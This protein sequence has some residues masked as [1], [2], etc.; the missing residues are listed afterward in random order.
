[1]RKLKFTL[2]ELLVVIAIIAILAAML[3]PALQ[4]ARDRARA[5]TCISNLKQCGTLGAQYMD[6]HNGF[7]PSGNS[8]QFMLNACWI[9][10]G[11]HRGKYIKLDDPSDSTWWTSFNANRVTAFNN[12][13]P[14][15]LRCPAVP[16]IPDYKG[17]QR[18]FIQSYGSNY[19]NGNKPYW[20]YHAFH[21]ALNKGY[22]GNGYAES[23]FVREIGPSDRLWLADSVN[24]NNIQVSIVIPW[25]NGDGVGSDGGATNIWS[26]L[27]PVHSG[28]LN[29]LNFSGGVTSP[30]P[31]ELNKY[32]YVRHVSSGELRSYMVR[33]YVDPEGGVPY[34]KENMISLSIAN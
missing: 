6:D 20:G 27:T 8:A 5:S 32:Y 18:C 1:M 17:S 28:R 31:V 4:Q 11:L 2:I 14:S 25:Y 10:A 21:P 30:A 9:F 22:N 12:S 16:N 33:C 26:Y 23:N 13:L 29:I 19:N 34:K 15:F 24:R 3:L 7:W